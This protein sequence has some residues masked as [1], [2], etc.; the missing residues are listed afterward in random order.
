MTLGVFGEGLSL[1]AIPAKRDYR[2]PHNPGC[3]RQVKTSD[4]DNDTHA[5]R[6]QER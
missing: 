4:G 1:S 5:D 3:T 2:P 6:Q